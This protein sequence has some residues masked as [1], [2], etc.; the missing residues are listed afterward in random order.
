MGDPND[1]QIVE[2][3]WVTNYIGHAI[4][5]AKAPKGQSKRF[6]MPQH[7]VLIHGFRTK[8]GQVQA[9]P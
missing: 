8:L 4:G 9:P 1:Q 2:I 5:Q 7:P 3:H 6:R